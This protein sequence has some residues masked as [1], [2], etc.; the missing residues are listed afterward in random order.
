[1]IRVDL[2]MHTRYCD[3]ANTPEEMVLAAI[4][5]GFEQ[6]GF[7]GHGYTDFDKSY[8]MSPEVTA[9]YMREIALLKE[10]Y[11]DRIDI[12]CGIE[13]DYY[14]DIATDAFDYVIGSVHY[15]KVGETY[16]PVDES[17]AILQQ[18]AQEHFAG[19]I[20]ALCERYFETVAD[21]VEKTDADIIGHFDLISKFN[22]GGA[23]FEQ[24]HE[25]YVRAWQSSAARL[26]ASGALFEINTGAI[27]RGYRTEAYPSAEMRAFLTK[28]GAKWIVSSDAHKK[29][30]I[31]FRFE[32][33]EHCVPQAC[34]HFVPRRERNKQ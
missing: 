5:K 22:E 33:Y 13:K 25:R 19:D 24:T 2:H 12:L 27:S 23:L 26:L 29:D 16:I 20:Y 34:T 9:H 18:A 10:R 11:R 8:C 14:S 28:K 1:M 15:L 21:V 3:G 6:I 7:S 32:T 30:D 4:E 31:G 17:P